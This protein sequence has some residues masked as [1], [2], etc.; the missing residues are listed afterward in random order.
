MSGYNCYTYKWLHIYCLFGDIELYSL[1]EQDNQLKCYYERN[2]S[3]TQKDDISVHSYKEIVHVVRHGALL[4]YTHTQMIKMS[5]T[6]VVATTTTV[7][8]TV[9]IIYDS[10]KFSGY[11]QSS[12]NLTFKP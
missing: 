6:L 8:V 12:Y 4:T 9:H 10:P 2:F 7:E 3:Q 5:R 11:T 1:F